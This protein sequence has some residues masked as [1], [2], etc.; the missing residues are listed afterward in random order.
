MGLNGDRSGENSMNK[1]QIKIANKRATRIINRKRSY[2]SLKRV[3]MPRG[4]KGTRN[5]DKADLPG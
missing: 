3:A 2:G 4:F 1:R 5:I